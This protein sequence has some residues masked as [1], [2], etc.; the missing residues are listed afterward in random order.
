M[1]GSKPDILIHIQVHSKPLLT[2][3]LDLKI[4]SVMCVVVHLAHSL[5]AATA[6]MYYVLNIFLTVIIYTDYIFHSILVFL[7][8]CRGL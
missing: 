1:H 4:Y 6:V 3:V 8:Y 7:K 5:D 2:F